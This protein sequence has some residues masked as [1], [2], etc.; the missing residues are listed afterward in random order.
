MPHKSA[1]K[2]ATKAQG[3]IHAVMDEYKRGTLKS[4]S[5]QKVMSR[6]QATAIAMSESGQ[7]RKRRKR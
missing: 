4:S 5:G 2:K 6:R 7:S 1:Y 3:K